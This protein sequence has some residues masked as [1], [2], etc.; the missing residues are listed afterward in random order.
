MVS[1]DVDMAAMD[2]LRG[3]PRLVIWLRGG[4]SATAAVLRRHHADIVGAAT[5]GD[6]ARVEV[7]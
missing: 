6:V 3:P 5:G 1:R 7:W 4:S 2:A